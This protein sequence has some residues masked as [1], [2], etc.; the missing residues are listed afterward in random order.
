MNKKWLFLIGLIFFIVSTQLINVK[1]EDT[2][3]ET[4]PSTGIIYFYSPSCEFCI[5]TEPYIMDLK[6]KDGI[7]VY[8]YDVET[9]GT[10]LQSLSDIYGIPAEKR[11]V[12]MVFSGS[13]WYRTQNYIINNLDKIKKD[14]SK[15]LLKEK[16]NDND[17]LAQ[18]RGIAGFF[19]V[20]FGGLIDGVNPCAMAML[21]LFISLLVGLSS[22]KSTLI[23]VSIA[24]ILGLFITYFSLGVFLVNIYRYIGPYIKGLT[25]YLNIFLFSLS[26]FLCI[27]NLYDYFMAKNEKYG[28]IKNQLP[29]GIQKFNKKLIKIFTNSLNNKNIF[30]VYL[31]AFALGILISL[32]EFLCTGQ[33]YLPIALAIATKMGNISS[34]LL[35]FLYNVMFIVPLIILA[36]IA[37]KTQSVISTSDKIR[38]KMHLIKLIT[39]LLFLC[40]A[41]YYILKILGVM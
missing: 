41:I 23:S 19:L 17:A 35:L 16:I 12:P 21:I 15:P 24:Y 22:K 8:F 25:L 3:I 7:E 4:I 39:G 28:Q 32:T 29:K 26:I 9:Y 34:I 11:T 37:I 14:S 31:I 2:T 27:F 18:Y 5:A 38:E 40:I 13:N 6:D 10:L 36:I 33:I 30:I 1:A 20:L